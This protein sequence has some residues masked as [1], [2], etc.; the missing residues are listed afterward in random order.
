M[1]AAELGRSSG[2][3]PLAEKFVDELNRRHRNYAHE[4]FVLKTIARK[5]A[6]YVDR[7]PPALKW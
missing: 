3:M 6:W 7:P 5:E 4:H 1:L 2:Y